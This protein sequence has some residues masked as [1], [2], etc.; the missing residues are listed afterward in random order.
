MASPVLVP[1]L[2]EITVGGIVDRDKYRVLT[3]SEIQKLSE[4][5]HAR[6][7][8][9]PIGFAGRDV[10]KRKQVQVGSKHK[11]LWNIDDSSLFREW[12]YTSCWDGKK[13][14]PGSG[15]FK[16]L[17]LEH[18]DSQSVHKM[19]EAELSVFSD[20]IGANVRNWVL[21]CVKQNTARYTTV[22]KLNGDQGVKFS[23]TGKIPKFNG[24]IEPE[25]QMDEE[26]EETLSS[27]LADI[28]RLVKKV[29]R[30]NFPLLIQRVSQYLGEAAREESSKPREAERVSLP[31]YNQL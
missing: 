22:Q 5:E 11:I 2:D 29:G 18:L 7:M 31:V 21:K 25:D 9:Q 6:Y 30:K 3:A 8:E 28:E 24:F 23:F 20:K 16:D 1:P 10:Y 13:N 27:D 14:S 4:E 19:N 12:A 17:F 15:E 26:S